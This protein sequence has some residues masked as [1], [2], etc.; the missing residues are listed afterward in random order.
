MPP[1]TIITATRMGASARKVVEER[2]AAPV[3][4]RQYM[5]L[6]EGVLEQAK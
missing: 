1:F 2:Y 6:Y 5:A 3:I 4:A